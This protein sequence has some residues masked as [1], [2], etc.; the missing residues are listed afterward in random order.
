MM[1]VRTMQKICNIPEYYAIEPRKRP[2]TFAG[3]MKHVQRKGGFW[4]LSQ[5]NEE[6]GEI[7][8]QWLENVLTDNG[9]LSAWKNSINYAASAVSVF[10][11]IAIDTAAG[12]TTL[13]TALTN[14][15]TGITSLSVAALPGAIAS[16]SSVIIG[17]GTGQTQTVTTTA[18]ANAGATSITVSSFTANA[19]YAVGSN[20]APQPNASDNPS[21]LSGTVAYSGALP[22]G[23]F[24]YSGSGTGN[25]QVQVQYTFSTSTTAGNYTEAWVTN[26]N[27]VVSNATAVHLI[28][29]SPLAINSTTSGTVTIIEKM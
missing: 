26:A 8:E 5:K 10:N 12:V 3:L 21:S 14:G 2:R 1:K 23:D 16:G 27:P 15:Q 7:N 9:A 20:V 17:A 24:S 4:C 19:A 6:T 18:I 13:Q 11:Q 29:N 25:R 22:S 28:F